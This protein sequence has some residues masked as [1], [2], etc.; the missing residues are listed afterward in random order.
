MP[1]IGWQELFLIA[2]VT[3]L[4]VGPKEIPRVLR[5]VT[6]WIQKV[7]SMARDFQRGIDDLVVEADLDDFRKDMEAA[8]GFDVKRN[9]EEMI[10]PTGEY[11][12][13]IQ[14][15]EDTVESSLQKEPDDDS[16]AVDDDPV[17][18]AAD[19]PDGPEKSSDA[20]PAKTPDA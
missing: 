17:P 15:I 6:Q 16:S 8:K 18:P 20:P 4:V 3:I 7:R 19:V 11:A 5:T 13:S 12:K 10:D 9:I 14:D 1:D 2:L